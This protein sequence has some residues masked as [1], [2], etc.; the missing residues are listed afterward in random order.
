MKIDHNIFDIFKFPMSRFPTLQVKW[1]AAFRVLKIPVLT[2]T[3]DGRQL[4]VSTR[5]A[6]FTSVLET[7]LNTCMYHVDTVCMVKRGPKYISKILPRAFPCCCPWW[8]TRLPSLP[9][10]DARRHRRRV[11]RVLEKGVSV[12]LQGNTDRVK[13]RSFQQV[14]TQNATCAFAQSSHPTSE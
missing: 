9:E 14:G 4:Y 10:R 12:Q 8:R 6:W 5:Q 13:T 2:T 3:N 7:Y 1:G 11:A